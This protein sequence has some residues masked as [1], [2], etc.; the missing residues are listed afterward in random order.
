MHILDGMLFFVSSL[1][2]FC[3]ITVWNVKNEHKKRENFIRN[4]L[5]KIKIFDNH[6]QFI[7][8]IRFLRI[9]PNKQANKDQ[10]LLL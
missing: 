4:M 10:K 1:I 2:C 9:M 3:R 5:C 6:R 8:T 7:D